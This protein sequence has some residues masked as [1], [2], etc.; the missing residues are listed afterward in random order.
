MAME[1]CPECNTSVSGNAEYCPKCGNVMEKN[2]GCILGL[3]IIFFPILFSWFT[4]QKGYPTKTRV[5]A[6]AWL[7]LSLVG[8]CNMFQIK[9]GNVPASTDI[10][11]IRRYNLGESF[12]LGNIRYNIKEIRKRS[13][14]GNQIHSES[15]SK[16]AVFLVASYT[17][18]NTGN[19]TSTVLANDFKIK[20][21]SGRTYEPSNTANAA[22]NAESEN[23]EI[24]FNQ[25]QPG[26]KKEGLTA[27][28]VPKKSIEK[29]MTFV[30]PTKEMFSSKKAVIE[31]Q[32]N[33]DE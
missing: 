12:Q 16:G 18:E 15:P 31:F 29:P 17:I 19:E 27:F 1:K 14:I 10:K 22:L 25:L 4:L 7:A 21:S 28:E 26:I 33:S 30:I 20:D 6:F 13:V 3:A 23:K 2:V 11:Q 24:F 32:L 9:E 8:A 5:A